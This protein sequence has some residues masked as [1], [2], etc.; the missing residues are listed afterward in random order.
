[1]SK[2]LQFSIWN[3]ELEN[4]PKGHEQGGNRPFFVISSADYNS[5]SGTPIGFICSTSANKNNKRFTTEIHFKN[6]KRTSHVNITQIRTLDKIRFLNCI[7]EFVSYDLGISIISKYINQIVLN[8]T[9]NNDKFIS[10]LKENNSVARKQEL[11]NKFN[12]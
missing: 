8:G 10:I 7:E 3:V 5:R 9:L 2:I 12:N 6:S 11:L 1:M 4:K